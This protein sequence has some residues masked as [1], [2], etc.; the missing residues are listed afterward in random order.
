MLQKLE[1]NYG[2]KEL[3]MK[4]NSSYRNLSRFKLKFELKFKEIYMS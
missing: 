1:I 4:N 2:W 3:E